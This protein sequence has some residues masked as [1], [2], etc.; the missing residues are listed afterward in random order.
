MVIFAGHWCLQRTLTWKLWL[1]HYRQH[2]WPRR[3]QSVAR[4]SKGKRK[5]EDHLKKN[6]QERQEQGR[7]HKL[8]NG[9]SG[10]LKLLYAQH[11]NGVVSN[12]QKKIK[13]LLGTQTSEMIFGLLVLQNILNNHFYWWLTLIKLYKID[14]NNAKNCSIFRPY[15]VHKRSIDSMH[16]PGKHS[17]IHSLCQ[18]ITSINCLLTCQWCS[19]LQSHTEISLY[20]SKLMNLDLPGNTLLLWKDNFK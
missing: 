3:W 7:V 5:D 13:L 20:V 10:A 18:S 9:Q 19:H 6:C 16:Q 4:R 2:K 8:E 12:L 14:K 15:L 1:R 17:V 11:E